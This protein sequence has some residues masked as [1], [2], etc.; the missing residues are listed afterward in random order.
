[1]R[2]CEKIRPSAEVKKRNVCVY[3]QQQSADLISSLTLLLLRNRALQCT[4]KDSPKDLLP[5]SSFELSV[6]GR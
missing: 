1:M 6:N 2:E 4:W 5:G 3:E